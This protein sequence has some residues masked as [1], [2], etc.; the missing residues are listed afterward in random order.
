[1]RMILILFLLLG[2]TTFSSSLAESDEIEKVYYKSGDVEIE[3]PKKNGK[4]NGLVKW[5]YES[6]GLKESVTFVDGVE[7]GGFKRLYESGVVKQDGFYRKGRLE[8]VM[9]DFDESGNVVKSVVYD[10][11]KGVQEIRYSYY[12]SEN[13]KSRVTYENGVKHGES[14]SYLETGE[15][16]ARTMFKNG[17]KDRKKRVTEKKEEANYNQLENQGGIYR[18]RLEYAKNK[19]LKKEKSKQEG[20]NTKKSNKRNEYQ[21]ITK[22]GRERKI[23]AVNKKILEDEIKSY[24]S[25]RLKDSLEDN[26]NNKGQLKSLIYEGKTGFVEKKFRYD[27][28]GSLLEKKTYRNKLRHGESVTYN[29]WGDE[30]SKVMYINGEEYIK[31]KRSSRMKREVIWSV[32]IGYGLS[33]EGSATVAFNN[34][35]ASVRSSLDNALSLGVRALFSADTV[36]RLGGYYDYRAGDESV[37]SYGVMA[38]V[39]EEKSGVY[40]LAGFGRSS[41][42]GLSENGEHYFIGIGYRS[43]DIKSENALYTELTYHSIL[44]EGSQNGVNYSLKLNEIRFG[45]SVDLPNE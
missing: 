14:I 44:S 24:K 45:I 26:G 12:D 11:G 40:G 41:F 22:E 35:K 36:L 9:Q 34:Y 42:S 23:I 43:R 17:Y 6:G 19:R 27:R 21:E 20:V 29:R 28:L 25:I 38:R 2:V 7:H 33:S 16:K 3:I 30:V 31:D 13:I 32:N 37:S 5:F 10:K 39:R 18:A 8:G 4:K 1:M 15:I